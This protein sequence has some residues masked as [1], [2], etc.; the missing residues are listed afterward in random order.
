M[1]AVHTHTHPHLPVRAHLHMAEP[2]SNTR[3]HP[4]LKQAELLQGPQHL[5]QRRSHPSQALALQL[6]LLTTCPFIP[7]KQAD[8]SHQYGLTL[9]PLL[10]RLHPENQV[11]PLLPSCFPIRSPAPAGSVS[12][13]VADGLFCGGAAG[14]HHP[15]LSCCTTHHSL[16][17][18]G[19]QHPGHGTGSVKHLGR[20]ERPVW[21]LAANSSAASACSGRGQLPK[22]VPSPPL[23]GFG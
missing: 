12:P 7:A 6:F 1:E 15:H 22:G 18:T 5:P 4:S 16:A 3:C 21:Y 10:D 20:K 14:S 8:V 2:P 23:Q 9:L 11:Q 13:P 19:H 17:G